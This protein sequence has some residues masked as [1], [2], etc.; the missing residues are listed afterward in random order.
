MNRDKLSQRLLAVVNYIPEG[1]RI[2]DIGS[3]HAY[4]PCFAVKHRN[5]PFAI[6]GEVADGPFTSA[7]TEVEDAGLTGEISVRKGD[8]LAVIEVGEVDCVTIAGMGGPLIASILEQGKEKLTSVQRLILQPNI[9]AIAIRKWLIANGWELIAEEII[10]EDDKV[11]EIIV[12]EQ[13][14]ASQPYS[15]E[16]ESD[17]LLGPFLKKER[18]DVFIKKWSAEIDKWMFVLEQL[19]QATT[20]SNTTKKRQELLRKIAMVKE[21]I[22][23]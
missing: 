10:E 18:S 16:I 11:Y 6:A 8:G 12:A 5:V 1:A 14:N 19:E 3:D 9:G 4:L 22:Q 20:S 23:T 21:A 13:G 17:L 15:E 7:L 2:A